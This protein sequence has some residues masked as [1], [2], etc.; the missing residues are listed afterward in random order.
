M[1]DLPPFIAAALGRRKGR[2]IL[3]GFAMEDAPDPHRLAER[4]LKRKG[5]DLIV[6]NGPAN[7]GSDA[8]LVE[9]FTPSSGWSKPFR[10]SKM[11]VARRIVCMIESATK[12]P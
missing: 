11:A 7:V 8:A 12:R 4:K 9:F 10:G 5:C 6:L 2:R 1:I 3:V